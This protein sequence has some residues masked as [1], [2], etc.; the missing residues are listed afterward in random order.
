[1]MG[2]TNTDELVPVEYIFERTGPGG[3]LERRMIPNIYQQG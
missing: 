2:E 3:C 1:M